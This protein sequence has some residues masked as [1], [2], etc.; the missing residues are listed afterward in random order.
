MNYSLFL[1]IFNELVNLDYKEFIL[2]ILIY[3]D[4]NNS[5]DHCKY[6]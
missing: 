4:V 2:K 1:T 5:V 3:R 6:L